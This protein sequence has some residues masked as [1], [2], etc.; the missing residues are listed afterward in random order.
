MVGGSEIYKEGL[1]QVSA[2]GHYL[3]TSPSTSLKPPFRSPNS[4][5]TP[6]MRFSTLVTALVASASAGAYAQS[7]DMAYVTAVIEALK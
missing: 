1:T 7:V 6:N 5:T 4:Q 2:S 3:S